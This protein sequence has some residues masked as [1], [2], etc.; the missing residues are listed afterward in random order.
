M[1]AVINFLVNELSDVALL[2]D[3]ICWW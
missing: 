1:A 2:T 3:G